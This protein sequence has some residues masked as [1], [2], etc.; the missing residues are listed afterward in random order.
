MFWVRS[1][2]MRKDVAAHDTAAS[3]RFV[4]E[5]LT[6]VQ[7]AKPTITPSIGGRDKIRGPLVVS[8]VP[9]LVGVVALNVFG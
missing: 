6:S 8:A 7:T 3:M 5:E 2:L 4:A 1:L 9:T